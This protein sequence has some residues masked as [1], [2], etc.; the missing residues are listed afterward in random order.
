M[1]ATSGAVREQVFWRFLDFPARWPAQ[2]GLAHLP[3]QPT[4]VEE[5]TIR[6]NKSQ[7]LRANLFAQWIPNL[8]TGEEADCLNSRQKLRLMK[9]V[10]TSIGDAQASGGERTPVVLVADNR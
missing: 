2:R 5:T 3:R 9:R 6:P 1:N 10:V 8:R 4:V 7:E